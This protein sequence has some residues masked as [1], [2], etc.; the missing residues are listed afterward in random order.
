MINADELTGYD[1]IAQAELVRHGS[2]SHVSA[3]MLE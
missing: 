3:A 2:A 1:A